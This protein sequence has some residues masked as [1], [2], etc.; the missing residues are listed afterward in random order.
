MPALAEIFDVIRSSG[1][2]RRYSRTAALV[3]L[4]SYRLKVIRVAARAV[5]AQVV[6]FQALR[7]RP[8]QVFPHHAVHR[9]SFALPADAAIALVR[10]T[11]YPFPA[12]ADAHA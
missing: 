3:L 12:V 2:H 6:E 4:R 7:D 9:T 8:D 10:S 5:L 11:A 1:T